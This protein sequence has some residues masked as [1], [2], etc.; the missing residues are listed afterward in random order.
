MR[1]VFGLTSIDKQEY[2]WK[3]SPENHLAPISLAV[4]VLE[5]MPHIQRVVVMEIPLQPTVV[6][7]SI[8]IS[9]YPQCLCVVDR[10]GL[11]HPDNG[12]GKTDPSTDPC[13][14][15]EKTRD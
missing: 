15:T 3:V 5:T 10:D 12:F 1:H 9:T 2:H 11:A 8:M 7:G 14:E 13:T 4:H 6:D